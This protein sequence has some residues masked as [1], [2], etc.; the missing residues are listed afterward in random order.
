VDNFTRC[1]REARA[2]LGAGWDIAA[3]T[4]LRASVGHFKADYRN[5]GVPLSAP[6]RSD[7]GEIAE[8]R[9]EWRALRNVVFNAGWQNC[10]QDS[11]DAGSR[12]SG[13]IVTF[14]GSL[15]L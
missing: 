3:R 12:F 7:T 9:A 2:S 14:G 11:T 10:R 13:R 6:A 1:R 5:P 15:L 8:L 4:P